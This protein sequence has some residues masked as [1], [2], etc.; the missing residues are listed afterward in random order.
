MQNS[1]VGY[2]TNSSE[3]RF[4]NDPDSNLSAGPT[5]ISMQKPDTDY[6]QQINK[7]ECKNTDI[8]VQSIIFVSVGTALLGYRKSKDT[9]VIESDNKIENT[10]VQEV[11]ED[12]P[13]NS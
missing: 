10:S 3:A 8:L 6:L 2:G 5:N 12:Q 13:L 9:Q 7:P 1:K 4:V 11:K